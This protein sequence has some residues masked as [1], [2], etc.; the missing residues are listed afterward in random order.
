VLIVVEHGDIEPLP[1][2]AFDLEAAWG[3]DVLEVDAA[4]TQRDTSDD[5]DEAVRVALIDEPSVTTATMLPRVVKRV[6]A[7]GSSE[8]IRVTRATPGV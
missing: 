8:I 6:A 1:E 4:E 2:L 5:V 3:G 7:V